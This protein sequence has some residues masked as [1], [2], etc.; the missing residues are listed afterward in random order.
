MILGDYESA[1]IKLKCIRESTSC[2]RKPNVVMTDGAKR[3]DDKDT[4]STFITEIININSSVLCIDYYFSCRSFVKIE[5]D[6]G[7]TIQYY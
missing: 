7:K 6:F 4:Q 1:A 3:V 2:D 5:F